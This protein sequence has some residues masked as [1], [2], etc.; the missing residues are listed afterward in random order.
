MRGK[1][2]LNSAFDTINKNEIHRECRLK[3]SFEVDQNFTGN[4][5]GY[6]DV[7]RAKLHEKYCHKSGK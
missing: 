2:D 5:M 4:K 1:N 6:Q 3:K 7:I